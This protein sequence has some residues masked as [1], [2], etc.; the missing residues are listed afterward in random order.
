MESHGR[1]GYA[2][3][4][5]QLHS[6]LIKRQALGC[7]FLQ[8]GLLALGRIPAL[9]ER[10][11]AGKTF[12]QGLLRKIAK[13]LGDELAVLV[14]IFDALGDDAIDIDFSLRTTAGG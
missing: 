12:L 5:V 6:D 11:E 9:Q 1:G 4:A 14:E 13:R 10:I 7:Q 2:R 3:P 8:H